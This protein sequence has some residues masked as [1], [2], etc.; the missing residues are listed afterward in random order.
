MIPYVPGR[1][2]DEVK[3]EYGLKEVVK[4]A[5][6]ENP[7]GCSPKAKE[8]VIASLEESGLY[9]DGNCTRL[10]KLLSKRLAVK[11][12]ELIFGCGADELISFIG[13]AFINPGDECITAECTFSQYEASVCSMG[14]VMSYAPMKDHGF[15]LEAISSLVTEKTKAVFLANP[16]NPTGTAFT[17]DEQNRL[18]EKIPSNVL[19]I[20]DEAYGEFVD[21][22][23]YPDTLALIGK[24]PNL[25]WLKTFSKIYG[26]ASLRVGYAA[27]SEEIISLMEKVRPPFNVTIQGQAAA[28]A[29]YQDAEHVSKSFLSN[30][31]V[32]NSTCK[33]LDEMGISYIPS[34]ANFIMLD[35]G[36]DSR[37]AFVDLMKKGYITR[38]G[39][40]FKMDSYL[41]VTIGTQKQMEGFIKAL[42]EVLGRS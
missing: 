27:A 33:A 30:L 9:P 38:P 36:I 35:C 6:N 26:L 20:I 37:T 14:G 2:L 7:I 15:D 34:Q 10:R 21:M 1:S 42:G 28:E 19:A 11:Q 22:P 16:N 12:T 41:R 40:P 29:A 31:S 3:N 5:S 17:A 25:I 18:L 23:N 13:K 8:A 24:Y 4:L 39:Y 32:K